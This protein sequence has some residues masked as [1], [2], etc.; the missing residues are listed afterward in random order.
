MTDTDPAV[1]P[2]PPGSP[3][4]SGAP[5]REPT[6]WHSLQIRYYQDDKDALLLDAVRPLF[7][8]LADVAELPYFQQHWRRGP[9]LRL[10]LR[11]TPTAWRE[12]VRPAAEERLTAFLRRSPSTAV[13]DEARETARHARKAALLDE[14]GALSPWYPDN[15]LQTEPY[16]DRLHVLGSPQ[17]ADLLDAGHAASTRLA[18]PLLEHVRR[19]GHSRLRPALWLMFTFAHTSLPPVSRGFMSFASHAEGFFAQCADPDAV[20]A[21]F[22]ARFRQLRGELGDDLAAVL[23]TLDGS[24][25]L[26]FVADWARY[27]RDRK[28]AAL[29]LLEEGLI[30]LDHAERTPLTAEPQLGELLGLLLGNESYQR[31]VMSTTWFRCHR[32]AVNQLY[33]HLDRL[34]LSITQRFLLCYL[35]ARTVEETFGVSALDRARA[36]VDRHPAT[37]TP[38]TADPRRS[39]A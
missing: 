1:R 26:P 13:L 35:A 10:N 18:F 28:A 7:A 36:Y 11:T 5:D 17:L 30:D 37:P 27:V 22:E 34:G 21:A 24:G 29:P 39:R 16:E 25:R 2:C 23:D 9:H 19:T 31:E 15:T 12:V 8:E 38:E 14:R 20:R 3:Q 4:P 6:E 32:L 33:T